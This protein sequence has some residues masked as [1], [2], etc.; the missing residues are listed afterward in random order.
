VGVDS[1]DRLD[2]LEVFL[3]AVGVLGLTIAWYD[4]HD[5][6]GRERP[7]SCHFAFFLSW[8]VMLRQS[9]LTVQIG[10]IADEPQ[11]F[12]SRLTRPL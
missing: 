7:P 4:E 3:Y 5:V 6:V 8:N 2:G 12:S 1:F 10:E 11:A 9:R